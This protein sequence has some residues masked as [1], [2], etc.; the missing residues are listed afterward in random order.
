MVD[1][2]YLGC[3][4]EFRK[5]E[6]FT[7][8]PDRQKAYTAISAVERGMLDG[9]ATR[10]LGGPNHIKVQANKC[11][12]VMEFDIG[13]DMLATK[14]RM[15][16]CG[17]PLTTADALVKTGRFDNECHVDRIAN[18][19]NVASISA[20]DQLIIGEDTSNH[21]TNLIWIWDFNS[22]QLTRI[23]ATPMGSETTSP[24]WYTIGDWMYMTYVVQHP[25]G[26][27]TIH[28]DTSSSWQDHLAA[29]PDGM[30]QRCLTC[31]AS[32]R[33]ILNVASAGLTL[34]GDRLRQAKPHG[35]A[36]WDR[37]PRPLPSS[38]GPRFRTPRAMPG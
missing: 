15:L 36:P 3:T 35:S 24:Y 8:D 7:Y 2:A 33:I 17:T 29:N 37:S 18:P 21:V 26:A 22:L 31:F 23:A 11:G 34:R 4:T 5:W 16:T 19:D 12:C 30:M 27:G 9:D 13:A 32:L 25:Y 38:S 6:G 1:A 28:A 20:Y 14:A 10:D